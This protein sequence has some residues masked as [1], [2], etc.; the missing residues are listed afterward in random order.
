[1]SKL[2][3][4]AQI[5]Q[6]GPEN[7]PHLHGRRLLLALETALVSRVVVG[8]RVLGGFAAVRTHGLLLGR[9]GLGFAALGATT[10]LAS[11]GLLPPLLLLVVLESI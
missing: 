2:N 8:V 5:N 7:I 3:G 11:G 6:I 1:V 4:N 9:L 10:G